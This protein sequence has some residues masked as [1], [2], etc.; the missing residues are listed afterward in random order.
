[1]KIM[2]PTMNLT[3]SVSNK[4]LDFPRLTLSSKVSLKKKEGNTLT[5]T[6]LL[7]G[8]VIENSLFL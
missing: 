5:F 2:L 4:H 7:C 1:M 3:W 6:T 8:S